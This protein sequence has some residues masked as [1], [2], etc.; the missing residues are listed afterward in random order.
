MT[1]EPDQPHVFQ[2]SP[3]LPEG[4]KWW[5]PFAVFGALFGA[6]ALGWAIFILGGWLMWVIRVY[7]VTASVVLAVTAVVTFCVWMF[8]KGNWRAKALASGIFAG[9]VVLVAWVWLA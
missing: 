1:A 5:H 4:Q 2:R 8:V 6:G 3:G 9:L 7:V